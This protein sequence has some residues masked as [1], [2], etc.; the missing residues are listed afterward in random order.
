[1]FKHGEE[2]IRI[3][4]SWLTVHPGMIVAVS[5][6]L[7]NDELR[8]VGHEGTYS[9]GNFLPFT[10]ENLETQIKLEIGLK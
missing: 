7:D 4:S 9:K 3:N 2:L 6:T 1:M 10:L 8:L 5:K